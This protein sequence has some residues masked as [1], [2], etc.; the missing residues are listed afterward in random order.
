MASTKMIKPFANDAD[1]VGI[2]GL[3]VENGTDAMAMYGQIDIT[4]D[5][6]GLA[7]AHDLKALLDRI[8][9]ALEAEKNL[10]DTIAPPDKPD[11][12]ANPFA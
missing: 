5:K 10:P 9:Q 8:V 12:I 2:K 6:V 3:T 11:E 1:S 4:R 7:H